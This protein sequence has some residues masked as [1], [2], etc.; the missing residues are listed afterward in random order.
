[1]QENRV[2]DVLDWSWT[3]VDKTRQNYAEKQSQSYRQRRVHVEELIN[4]MSLEIKTQH[5]MLDDF[6]KYNYNATNI[7]AIK[8]L[9]VAGKII[10]EQ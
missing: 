7:F 3:A 6:I 9:I 8:Q 10:F 1:M 2:K 5:T 4:F